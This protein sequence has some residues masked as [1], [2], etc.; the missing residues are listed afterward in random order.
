MTTP[1]KRQQFDRVS[2]NAW[3]KPTTPVCETTKKP[4]GKRC[5]SIPDWH[6]ESAPFPTVI[7]MRPGV[8][9]KKTTKN[10]L[11][12][13]LLVWIC[14][15]PAAFFRLV[16]DAERK[17]PKKSPT[18]LTCLPAVDDRATNHINGMRF[19]RANKPIEIA[20][21]HT[22]KSPVQIPP[23]RTYLYSHKTDPL[24]HEKG[25]KKEKETTIRNSETQLNSPL[26]C[27]TR[28]RVSERDEVV[29]RW[30]TSHKISCARLVCNFFIIKF[31]FRPKSLLPMFLLRSAPSCRRGFHFFFLFFCLLLHKTESISS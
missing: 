11:K 21:I 13:R 3:K 24:G 20:S 29:I 10:P 14:F 15:A 17:C 9:E 19:D 16:P 27:H 30:A 31:N 25:G 2:K 5:W 4:T 6:L 7:T 28:A 26:H 8:A 18:F 12:T 23:F 1:V 22:H